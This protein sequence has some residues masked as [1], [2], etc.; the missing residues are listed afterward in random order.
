MT[1]HPASPARRRFAVLAIALLLLG[2]CT[3]EEDEPAEDEPAVEETA[4]GEAGTEEGGAEEADDAEPVAAGVADLVERV[5]P[6]VVTILVEVDPDAAP[7]GPAPGQEVP[8]EELP[9]GFEEQPD[10][11][12]PGLQPGGSGIVYGDDLVVTNNH[13]IA[14]AQEVG[15]V[16]ADG[17]RADAEVVA[18]DERTDVAVLRVA[19]GG[20]SLP[21]AEFRDELPRV[22]DVAVAIGSPL[23]LENTVTSGI[24]SGVDRAIPGAAAAGIPALTGL[25][26][27]DAALSPGNSG[28]ALIDA[29]GGIIG[30]N[31]AFIPPQAQAVSIGFAIPAAVVVD[32]A[33][34]LLADGEV[35]HAFLGVQLA[36]LL[37]MLREELDVEAQE[38]ALVLAVDEGSPAEEAGLEPGDVIVQVDD[39]PIRVLEDLTAILRDRSPG[40][41]VELMVLRDDD[42]EV[43]EAT[44]GERPEEAQEPA[45][46]DPEDLEPAP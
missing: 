32:V 5:A 9:P 29:D 35:N 23:G 14:I 20:G 34:Q 28:G 24:V 4:P 13:V 44:L 15:V 41:V 33:E 8:E 19:N 46:L 18:G 6:S 42:E 43:V 22:G 26:Q 36:P 31:I 17:S 3:P 1:R 38:G 27:T 11:P 10:V 45:E 16:F 25:I 21:A 2:A 7:G 40:D 37:P 39:E 30:M 12:S